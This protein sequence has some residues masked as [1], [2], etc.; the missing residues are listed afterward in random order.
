MQ[1][2]QLIIQNKGA[3]SL[4]KYVAPENVHNTSL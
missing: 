3:S 2:F 4:E 1:R